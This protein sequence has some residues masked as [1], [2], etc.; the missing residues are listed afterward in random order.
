MKLGPWTSWASAAGL[1]LL[2]ALFGSGCSKSL[3]ET[4]TPN[5]APTVT[6]TAAPIDT[7]GEYF[8]SV[9]LNWLGYDRDGK[10]VY[11]EYAVL[12]GLVT[13]FR[14]DTLRT[15]TSTNRNELTHFFTS[16][17]P[18]E[19]DPRGTKSTDLHTFVIRA[20]DN[21]GARS[22]LAW[23][24]FTSYT[25]APSVRI[26]SPAPNDI[27]PPFVT[28]SVFIQW[29]GED[30]DG[31]LTKKPVKY[32]FKLFNYDDPNIDL[33]NPYS[34]NKFAPLFDSP[35]PWDSSAA[36]T[37]FKLYTNLTQGRWVFVITAFDEA[38]AY[39]PVFTLRTNVL[40]FKVTLTAQ[41]GP[42][43]TVFNEFIDYT[44]L[45]GGYAT[46]QSRWI[47][48]EVPSDQALRWNWYATP[49]LGALIR[50]T[51]WKVDNLFE[52][53]DQTA[54]TDEQKDIYHWSQW[55]SVGQVRAD[56][57]SIT[58]DA[59]AGKPDTADFHYLYIEVEDNI[60]L[61]SLAIVEFAVIKPS[62]NRPLLIVDDRRGS[63][64][65]FRG[66]KPNQIVNPPT[67]IWPNES[68]LDTFFFAKGGFPWKGY[69]P[70]NGLP[71]QLPSPPG[72]FLG[73]PYDTFDTRGFLDPTMPLSVLG[74][75]SHVAWYIDALSAG[76][77][78]DP[79]HPSRPVTS[80]VWMNSPNH[81][82]TLAIYSK[83]GGQLFFFG[84]GVVFGS[85]YGWLRPN[86]GSLWCAT[87]ARPALFPG[88]FAYDFLKMQTC[89]RSTAA[90]DIIVH[91]RRPSRFAGLVSMPLR[92]FSGEELPPLRSS[93]QLTQTGGA[94][95]V[96]EALNVFEGEDPTTSP[97]V[98]DT[99]FGACGSGAGSCPS[100]PEDIGNPCG[101]YYHGSAHA[102]IIFLGFDLWTWSRAS[103]INNVDILLQEGM[104][105]AR[106]PL[107]RSPNF[108]AMR[109]IHR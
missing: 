58:L 23:R 70:E 28:P 60:G 46:D 74:R 20:V 79:A 90:S 82:N 5:E 40:V 102:P 98:F 45:S 108:S 8:Y 59:Y 56:A 37:T 93:G 52:L 33:T 49:P 78:E 86:P 62:F 39:D 95:I 89:V 13:P 17:R 88:R 73:Y 11:Y 69:G 84:G 22:K 109:T 54:R 30:P 72:V 29:Q 34:F 66:T 76:S 41:L 6:L 65:Q 106:Q 31:Q 67:G 97:V 61:T 2:T 7:V 42:V 63:A 81:S 71:S 24:S 14:L 21:E 64:D 19:I 103:V 100:D 94:E 1:T 91:P 4:L 57:Y 87:G 51:R 77:Y 15:F 9:H 47:R 80:M 35:T 43:I 44:Y 26:V 105:I 101:F 3:D 10:I 25:L 75:Y 38:G 53:T 50:R 104:G 48:V 27:F 107:P 55:A 12:D 92:R 32:K 99:L 36:D 16:T 18:K 68:E 83:Q 96:T 85:L